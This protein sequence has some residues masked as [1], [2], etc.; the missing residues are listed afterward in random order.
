MV[1][2]VALKVLEHLDVGGA[3]GARDADGGEEGA[4]GFR[5][6]AAAAEAGESGHAR[7][8]PAVDT[9]LLHELEQL[10]LAEQRVG[11]VE[12]VEFDLLRG[13]DAEL[14]DIPAVERLV[15][16]ELERA[17]GVG[18]VLDRIRLAVGVVV[19]RVDAP[20]V[21][22]AVMRGVE[23]AVHHRIAHVEVGRGHVDLG[24]EDAA[25]VGE[26]AVLHADEEVEIFFDGP[27]AIGAVLA[28]LGE[29]AAVLAD[30]VGG[31]VVDVGLAGLDELQGPLVELAEVVGG[32]AE[33]LPLEAEPADVLHD[34]ID[35]LLL[36]LL[37]IGVVEAQ[38][39][40]AAELVGEAEVE[41]DGLGVADVEVA[42]GLGRKAGLDDCV[43]V[44]FGA[45]ILGD[46]IAEEVGEGANVLSFRICVGHSSHS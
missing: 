10:A 8:V 35:V 45:H 28:G 14:L 39:G 33:A 38:V 16:G 6:E 25:A 42:V 41:A 40:L 1:E 21:A 3:V 15:V 26:L 23:D 7:I 18:D 34:G 30:L 36:F 24:A 2:V 27:V 32:V 9:I 31:E 11:D 17:H 44:L 46:L 43:A 4:D 29:G 37:G 13:K 20:L 19:H 12:T 5:R 22:G